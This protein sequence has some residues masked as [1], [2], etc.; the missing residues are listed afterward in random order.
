MSKFL[1]L[2]G[3]LKLLWTLRTL[4]TMYLSEF[5]DSPNRVAHKE[6]FPRAIKSRRGRV[7]EPSLHA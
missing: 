3:P 6:K 4:T 2:Q 1:A 7:L 5:K